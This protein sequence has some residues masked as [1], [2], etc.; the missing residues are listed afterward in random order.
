MFRRNSW[1]VKIQDLPVRGIEKGL[2]SGVGE[3]GNGFEARGGG[4]D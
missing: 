2:Q 3:V 4:G 1:Q